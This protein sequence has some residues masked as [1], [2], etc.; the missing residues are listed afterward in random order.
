MKK[1]LALLAALILLCLAASAAMALD[2]DDFSYS[3]IGGEAVITAYTGGA[4][5]LT[6]PDMLG[7]YPVTSI[8]YC[9]FR[10]CSTLTRVTLP[11]GVTSIGSNAFQHC[12]SLSQLI[13]PDSLKTIG[14]HAF[15]GCSNLAQLA[16]PDSIECFQG[17]PFYGSSAVRICSLYGQAARILT[18]FGYTFTCPEYPFIALTAHDSDGLRTFTVA[19]CDESALS[20]DFPAGTDAIER[21]AFFGCAALEEIILPEGV[22]EIPESAFEGCS[23]LRQITIPGSI[24]KIA[25]SA[26]AR[27]GNLTIIAPEGSA[28]QA[29]AAENGFVWQEW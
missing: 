21:Y 11:S 3:V 10:E 9:A 2:E 12:G 13:L 28:G 6:V 17:Y 20:V 4:S 26:F 16:I 14:T 7:G 1:R 25:E 18:D 19:D 5:E 24:E 29:F 15:Y 27:C 22:S 8:R 23:S